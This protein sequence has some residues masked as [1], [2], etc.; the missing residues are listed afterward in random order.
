M[1]VEFH[2]FAQLMNLQKGMP[3]PEPINLLM[4]FQLNR[5][6]KANEVLVGKGYTE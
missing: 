5:G 3:M 4:H 6:K 1:A 2:E